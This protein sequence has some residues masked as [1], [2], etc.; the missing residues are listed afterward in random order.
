MLLQKEIS[1][2]PLRKY[3]IVQ[4]FERAIERLPHPR[5]SRNDAILVDTCP[6]PVPITSVDPKTEQAFV[7]YPVYRSAGGT[8]SEHEV[9]LIQKQVAGGHIAGL[10][11]LFCRD[12]FIRF[13]LTEPDILIATKIYA[14]LIGHHSL[15]KYGDH[16]LED[17]APWLA[18]QA[19]RL[20]GKDSDYP[21]YS[22]IGGELSESDFRLVKLYSPDQTER[23]HIAS[24]ESQL[25]KFMPDEKD[26]EILL[27][28][29]GALINKHDR[30]QEISSST[31]P[32]L[33]ME[34]LAFQGKD[35][36]PILQQI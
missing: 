17:R 1:M 31:I 30:L 15:F 5:S 29:V 24:F 23:I 16:S 19:I 25:V 34:A 8:L 13:G 4:W 35:P 27:K 11:D 36:S 3:R 26:M 28:I 32:W 33:A 21:I 20:Q 18:I 7:S 10:I 2:K 6:K 12:L 14:L 22:Y 9:E